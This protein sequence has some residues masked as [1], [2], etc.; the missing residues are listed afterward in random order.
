MTLHEHQRTEAALAS[1]GVVKAY[2]RLE[3]SEMARAAQALAIGQSIGNPDIRVE[4]E[5]E[6]LIERHAARVV[7]IEG[8]EVEVHFPEGNFGAR[9]GIS[10]LMCTLLGG[11]VDI[12]RMQSCQLLDVDF[13]GLMKRFPGPRF[14]IDGIR[15]IAGVHGRPLI[16]GIVKPKIGL[17]PMQLA[18]VCQE[19]ARGGV[20][21]IKEDEILGD[22]PWCR[23]EERVR[24]VVKALAGS[25]TIYAPCITAD[26][27]EVVRRARLAQSLGAGA[28]HVNIW[29]GFAAHREVRE[30]V[31]IPLFFQKSGDKV[32]TTGPNSV[33]PAMLCKLVRVIGCDF[34]HVGM[35]GGYLHEAESE[36]RSRL[37]ALRGGWCEEPGVL[38][39]FSCGAHPGIVPALV[40]RF[41]EDVMISAG[42]AIHGHPMG[43]RAGARAFRQALETHR[44]G[45]EPRELATA[46]AKWGVR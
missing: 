3:S 30:N 22:A 11:Q 12:D 45:N 28:V 26:G 39:S 38:P 10:H 19:M 33:A 36:L 4:R 24:A 8:N 6:E 44:P 25:R 35:W 1:E 32:W 2:Y 21:F 17:S 20:D 23:L 5:T 43:P 16:G 9:D 42:G 14:G 27:Q 13:G 34:A 15:E 41:G 31:D 29:A 46:I 18:E 40:E 37:Y 7:S